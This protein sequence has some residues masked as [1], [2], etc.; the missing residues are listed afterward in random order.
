MRSTT[1][2]PNPNP[3]GD[4]VVLMTPCGRLPRRGR[5]RPAH[6][7]VQPHARDEQLLLAPLRLTL[8]LALTL[9]LT[10]PLP[11]PLPLTLT[12]NL[13]R[14]LFDGAYVLLF[15]LDAALCPSPS[16]PIDSFKG[17]ALVGAP[18]QGSKGCCN[19]GLSLWHRASMLRLI[20]MR[21]HTYSGK[22]IDA[23]P[24]PNPHPHPNPQ[25]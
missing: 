1:A 8:T 23:N 16:R 10:L 14:R 18:W 15:E 4:V 22:Q 20:A 11:L 9:P 19:S 21:G 17:F 12:L 5:L 3:N 25:P 6:E 13:T 7:L 2:H 24:H